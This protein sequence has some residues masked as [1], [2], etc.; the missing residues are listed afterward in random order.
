MYPFATA[1]KNNCS[2][3]LGNFLKTILLE[4]QFEKTC[5]NTCTF[6]RKLLQTNSFLW[7]FWNCQDSYL[8]TIMPVF[9]HKLH[10]KLSFPLRIISVNVTKSSGNYGF[11]HITEEIPNG[12]PQFCAVRLYIFN[13]NYILIMGS[14]TKV[15]S[16]KWFLL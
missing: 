1:L 8:W 4:Y 10:K 11:G 13:H 7:V 2:W 16:T 9:N 3:N 15:K 14:H 6:C 12:K 5:T